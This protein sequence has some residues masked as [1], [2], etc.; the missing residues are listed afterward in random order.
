MSAA[1]AQ[2][3]R[4]DGPLLLA[5]S[6]L[7][8]NEK[9]E[10]AYHAGQKDFGENYVQELIEKEIYF[11]KH[12]QLDLHF[13]FIGHL[14]TNKVKALLPHVSAIHSVDSLKLLQEIEK[15]AAELK[16]KISVYFQVNID[17]ET[18]KGGVNPRELPQFA[19]AAAQCRW[20]KPAGLMCIPD[21][22]KNSGDAFLQMKK[23]SEK[24]SSQ[25]GA[26]LSM[27]MSHDF[28][29]AIRYGSTVVRIGTAIFGERTL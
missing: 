13:H 12:L 1:V 20:L 11:R 10:E 4:V 15:R 3:K 9:I 19:E 6:K 29:A 16:K 28:E 25:L 17:E 26:G 5:V 18:S 24:Y 7:Q 27:G 14:Q 2:A 8:P 23:L 21:P 22:T